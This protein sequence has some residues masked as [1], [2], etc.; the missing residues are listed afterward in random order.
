MRHLEEMERRANV[1]RDEELLALLRIAR[2]A[3]AWVEAR[4]RSSGTVEERNALADRLL[5]AV[6]ES[7]I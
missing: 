3:K 5:V 6:R 2:A 7:G 1:M 4:Q